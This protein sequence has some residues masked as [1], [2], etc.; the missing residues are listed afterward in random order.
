MSLLGF[1]KICASW[2][3]HELTDDMKDE[4]VTVSKEIVSLFEVA[5]EVFLQRIVT[6]GGSLVHHCDP[7]KERLSVEYCHKGSP[8]PTQYKTKESAG[9]VIL[10]VFWNSEGVVLTGF[11]QE[12]ATVNSEH[13]IETLKNLKKTYREERSR[14]DDVLLQSDNARPHT[15]AATTDAI[16]SAITRSLQSGSPSWRFPLVRQSVGRPHRGQNFSSD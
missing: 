13:Y 4:Q 6:G 14:T 1:P 10:N 7:E 8:A 12:G 5:G 15:S 3:P 16:S 2:A 11:L 9:K